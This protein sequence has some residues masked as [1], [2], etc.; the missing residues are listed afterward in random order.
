MIRSMNLSKL[1]YLILLVS[2]IST[3]K[4][5]LKQDGPNFFVNNCVTFDE[6]GRCLT[7]DPNYHATPVGQDGRWHCTPVIPG[8]VQYSAFGGCLKC[9]NDRVI[10]HRQNILYMCKCAPGKRTIKNAWGYPAFCI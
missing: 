1:V 6:N 10:V 4:S 3:L 5:K 7:C 8:C 9:A 2:S